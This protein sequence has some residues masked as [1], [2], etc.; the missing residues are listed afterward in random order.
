MSINGN[1]DLFCVKCKKFGELRYINN[2]V[3]LSYFKPPKFNIA[4]AI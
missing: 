4:L 2:K 3:L 1:Y